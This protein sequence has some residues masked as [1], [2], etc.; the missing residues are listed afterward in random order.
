MSRKFRKEYSIIDVYE[1]EIELE[2]DEIKDMT[3]EEILELA[4]MLLW[5]KANNSTTLSLDDDI[6]DYPEEI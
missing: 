6:M 2:E 4:G 3:E 1:E 5:D